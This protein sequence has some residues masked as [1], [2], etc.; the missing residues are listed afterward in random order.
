M[1]RKHVRWLLIAL[2]VLICSLTSVVVADSP[3][4]LLLYSEGALSPASAAFA[5]GLR[6]GLRPSSVQ[7]EE[8]HLDISRFA[9]EALDQAL[10]DWLSSRHREHRVSVVVPLGVPASVFA[11]RFAAEIW[12]GVRIVHAA[13][14]GAQLSAVMARGEAVVPRTTDYRRTVEVGLRLF[15]GTRQVSLIAGATEQDRRWLDQAEADLA[16]FGE[17][18]RIDRIAELRWPEVVERVRRLPEDSVAIFIRFSADADGRTFSTPDV[19]PEIARVA[20]RPLFVMYSSLLGSGALGGY[21]TDPVQMARQAADLV[22]H[23]LDNPAAAPPP[24]DVQPQLT[25]DAA[26]LRRWNVDESRLPAGAIVLNRELPAWRRYLWP[27][28][29]TSL[30]VAAQG[31]IIGALLMQR[32]QRRRVEAALRTS[33]ENARASYDEVRDLAGRLISAREGERTRIARDLHDDIG[34]RVASFSIG[35]SRI[36][37]QLSNV[38]SPARQGLS[39]LEKQAMRLSTDLRHLSHEL[40]PSSLEHLGFLE[41][42]RE[43]CDDFSE[44]SGIAVRLDVSD[45]W[46]DVTDATALCLYRVAQEALRNVATHAAARNVTLSLEQVDE[47]LVMQVTDD[48]CG[49]DPAATSRRAGLG[50]VSL[51]ERVR[52]LSGVLDVTAAPHA[53]TRI[54]V[55]LP[56]GAVHAPYSTARG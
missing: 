2:A 6:D 32:R 50:L 26:Q 4:V 16:P 39:D 22:L 46:P 42:L 24:V 9:G 54:S 56:T 53:G 40:H 43:R 11:S 30:L 27:I 49:F 36:Q 12:P 13:I 1:T 21:F 18:L 20:N 5:A 47:Q 31:A 7:V 17:R 25:L 33:E 35:L 38:V 19:L 41:A 45:M 10:A 34:Q 48:G 55:R 29:A 37:R 8:Q 15:P 3:T 52:M 51:S 44:E 28:V 14:D 23:V